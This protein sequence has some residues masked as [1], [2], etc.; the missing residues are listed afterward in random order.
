MASPGLGIL[1]EYE[2]DRFGDFKFD[3]FF[4]WMDKTLSIAKIKDYSFESIPKLFSPETV[5]ANFL[6]G[7]ALKNKKNLPFLDELENSMRTE[8]FYES[9]FLSF[10]LVFTILFK[11][12]LDDTINRLVGRLREINKII[13]VQFFKSPHNQQIVLYYEFILGYLVHST[14]F[15]VFKPDE[16]KVSAPR[17]ILNCY[18]IVIFE[19]R[20]LLVSDYYLQSQLESIFSI[21]SFYYLNQDAR[22]QKTIRRSQ[23]MSVFDERMM[24]KPSIENNTLFPEFNLIRQHFKRI[25]QMPVKKVSDTLRYNIIQFYDEKAK[26]LAMQDEQEVLGG[27]DVNEAQHNSGEKQKAS[28]STNFRHKRK[29][30]SGNLL[31][32]DCT[33]MGLYKKKARVYRWGFPC[34][35]LSPAIDKDLAA[36][37]KLN[38]KANLKKTMNL[39]LVEED[40]EDDANLKKYYLKNSLVKQT[41]SKSQGNLHNLSSGNLTNKKRIPVNFGKLEQYKKYL[42]GYEDFIEMHNHMSSASIPRQSYSFS[43]AKANPSLYDIGKPNR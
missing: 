30:Q 34:N 18:H 10:W 4:Q 33:E 38:L 2:L 43:A 29:S 25:K 20:G 21:Q 9:V 3:E 42:S 32:N 16:E 37:F 35:K 23:A 39:T 14:M 22:I 36:S 12:H 13:T 40:K 28:T 5:V 31:F 8:T 19:R 17:F 1:K 15:E 27:V 26:I 7:N 6:K 24:K 11:P 41:T